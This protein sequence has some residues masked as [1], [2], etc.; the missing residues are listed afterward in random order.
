MFSSG[1]GLVVKMP[2]WGAR[3]GVKLCALAAG[4]LVIS[5]CSQQ[6]LL[7]S[8][9]VTPGP[10]TSS[11]EWATI[12]PSADL[13][14]DPRATPAVSPTS[15]EAVYRQLIGQMQ[16]SGCIEPEQT[17]SEFS[18]A[19]RSWFTTQGVTDS[20][21]W[22]EHESFRLVVIEPVTGF[23][24]LCPEPAVA[25]FRGALSSREPAVAKNPD[26]RSLWQKTTA[27]PG[28]TP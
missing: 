15:A 25:S 7:G 11:S 22:P 26:V 13:A 4:V 18:T 6:G 3:L 12:V 10:T 20:T 24:N 21:A 16:Q 14:N 28:S 23:G 8:Q 9:Y 19:W 5:G 17:V 1:K 27:S 2:G